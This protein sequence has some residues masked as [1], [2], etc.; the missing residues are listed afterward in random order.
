MIKKH[1]YIILRNNINEG[2]YFIKKEDAK[3]YIKEA[4]KRNIKGKFEI[5]NI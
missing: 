1:N 4:K 2:I 3:N 5:K